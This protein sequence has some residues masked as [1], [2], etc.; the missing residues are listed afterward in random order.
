MSNNI[1]LIENLS[2]LI[3]NLIFDRDNRYLNLIL[4]IIFIFVICE[5]KIWLQIDYSRIYS[6]KKAPFIIILFI[7]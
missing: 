5:K 1:V 4:T 6:D 2:E 7:S 3:V